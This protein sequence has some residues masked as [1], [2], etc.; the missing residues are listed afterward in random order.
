MWR[1]KKLIIC[2]ESIEAY[3]FFMICN[4]F[5]LIEDHKTA[6]A[7][8]NVFHKFSQQLKQQYHDC[9]LYFHEFTFFYRWWLQCHQD[10]PD[11]I[12]SFCFLSIDF[13]RHLRIFVQFSSSTDGNYQ[14]HQ[15]T[16]DVIC[17]FCSLSKDFQYHLSI[18]VQ[19]GFFHR[20]WLP[21]HQAT[22]DAIC[23]L[24]SLSVDFP[25]QYFCSAL[26]LPQT[27]A[28]VPSSHPWCY[29]FITFSVC[30]LPAPLQYFCS[31]CLMAQKYCLP[32]PLFFF[33]FL[34]L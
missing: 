28:P 2:A 13:Q 6:V 1:R 18:S 8:T 30:R 5:I 23:S 32:P 34:M 29:L 21:Y 27:V 33:F 3:S 25:P 19:F 24:R 14:Y 17:S 22:P 10:T 4:V 11:V 31:V 9:L 26:F 7:H 15:D 16:P 12:C 20:Q